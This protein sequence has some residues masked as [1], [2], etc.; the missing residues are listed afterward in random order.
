MCRDALTSV[1]IVI[2]RAVRARAPFSEYAR[3]CTHAHLPAY[4][5]ALLVK[6]SMVSSPASDR[7]MKKSTLEKM[8]RLIK[9]GIASACVCVRA[10]VRARMCACVRVCARVCARVRVRA[11]DEH[12][13]SGSV[14]GAQHSYGHVNKIS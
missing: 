8:R 3:A 2:M 13:A 12:E 6:A 11:R 1:C 14:L 4:I 9:S 7:P 10:C 5:L